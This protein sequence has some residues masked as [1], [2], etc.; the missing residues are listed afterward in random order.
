[1]HKRAVAAY[2]VYADGFCRPIER[3]RDTHRFFCGGFFKRV[4]KCCY[5]RYGNSLVYDRNTV[6]LLYILAYLD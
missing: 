6:L 2:K 4:Y 5:G 3:F 1:M